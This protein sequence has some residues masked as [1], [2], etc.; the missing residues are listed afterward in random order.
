M[1]LPLFGRAFLV[2][3]ECLIQLAHVV[4]IAAPMCHGC[5]PTAFNAFFTTSYSQ[6][7]FLVSTRDRFLSVSH[8]LFLLLNNY[9][10]YSNFKSYQQ[11]L[12]SMTLLPHCAAAASFPVI[13]S[14]VCIPQSGEIDDF[15][16]VRPWRRFGLVLKHI[17]TCDQIFY[18]V[19]LVRSNLTNRIECNLIIFR[20]N[21]RR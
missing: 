17:S 15:E 8:K 10:F 6:F 20:E 1:Q 13:W 11:N 12:Q 9:W 4:Y 14:I 19:A 16:V 2:S 5:V 21:T 7:L 3:I 18:V